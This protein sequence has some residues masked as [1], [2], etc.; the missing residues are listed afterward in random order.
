MRET[1][2]HTPLSLSTID[3]GTQ[4]RNNN[5]PRLFPYSSQLFE[6]GYHITAELA[7]VVSRVVEEGV[8]IVP[9]HA[10]VCWQRDFAH[11]QQ[12]LS[13]RVVITH[14]FGRDHSFYGRFVIRRL[15][16]CSTHTQNLKSLQLFT[17]R[18]Y[19]S[20]LL[21]MGLCLSVR[22]KSEFCRNG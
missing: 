14:C 2:F 15:G 12:S 3:D 16:L 13:I 11:S 19:A 9:Q 17:A 6:T 1:S 22:H 4:L 7:P 10:V 5:I 21:A 18:C 20:A 8:A